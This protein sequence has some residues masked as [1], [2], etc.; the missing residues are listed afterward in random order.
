MLLIYS[1]TMKLPL[2]KLVNEFVKLLHTY[3]YKTC[4][5]FLP[6]GTTVSTYYPLKEMLSFVATLSLNM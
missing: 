4:I 6:Y 3:T 1:K 5:I 2:N